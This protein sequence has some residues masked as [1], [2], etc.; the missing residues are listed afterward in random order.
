MDISPAN[1]ILIGNTMYFIENQIERNWFE[2]RRSC[3]S[4]GYN[5]I[6]LDTKKKFNAINNYL[7]A[8]KDKS[9]YWTSGNDFLTLGRHV[10]FP[11]GKEVPLKYWYPGD[12][13]NK[14][15]AEHCDEFRFKGTK[16]M[17]DEK[18]TAL[19]YYICERPL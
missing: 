13:S 14:N 5:L 6:S 2:A 10:W 4:V 9:P 18:C 1:Q 11:S 3:E 12:P 15:G 17:N 8:Q 7:D 16:L 19:K